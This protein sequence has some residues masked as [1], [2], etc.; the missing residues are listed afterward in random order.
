[1]RV[2]RGFVARHRR[3]KVLRYTR[4]YFASSAHLFRTAYQ[5]Y[6]KAGRYSYRS[7]RL[8][9]RSYRQLWVCRANAA[10]RLNAL[11]Y[12]QWQFY[13]RAYGMKLNRK[14]LSQLILRD[15]PAFQA[16][17]LKLQAMHD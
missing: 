11:T 9:K 12:S 7:R 6:L 1:M 5:F 4:S 17:F 2:K 16:F 10:V 14:W 13:Q 15:Y 8:R 3:K